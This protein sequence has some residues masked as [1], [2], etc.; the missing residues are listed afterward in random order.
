MVGDHD[1][2]DSAFD[3]ALIKESFAR[4]SPRA[5]HM[6]KYFYAHLFARNPEVREMFPET[7][8]EQRD[9]LVGALVDV[10]LRLDDAPALVAYLEQL[11]RD[12][13]KYDVRA[14]HYPAVGASLLAT[15]EFLAGP[16]W[17]EESAA[18]WAAA[19]RTVAQVMTG[20]ADEVPAATRQWWDADVV[21][22]ERRTATIAVLTVRPRDPFDFVPGQ[23]VSV[24]T[25]AFPKVWRNYSVANAPRQDGT[26]ELHVR[27]VV[28]G[29]VSPALVERTRVGDVLRLGPAVGTMM[30]DRCS[31]RE[32]L[33]VA[34]GTGLAPMKA[35]VEQMVALPQ[36]RPVRM[37]YGARTR[38]DLYDLPTMERLA[39]RYDWLS[40]VPVVS[41]DP[42]YGGH[43]GTLAEAVAG[44]GRWARHD[45][46]VCG[47]PAMV[48]ATVGR[49]TADGVT[50]A[51]V[52]R[53]DLTRSARR[54]AATGSSAPSADPALIRDLLA[55]RR[56]M[57]GPAAR[58][59]YGAAPR[60]GRDD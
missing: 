39:S 5:D 16:A 23:Y 47:S 59:Y 18:A 43:R 10:M 32:V 25:P 56:A 53:D 8:S 35:M 11:G 2:E 37:F 46:Y 54:P 27:R 36:P 58:S 52:R 38:G 4:V 19:Y 55:A 17:T 13:R 26:L 50:S 21:G 41:D 9:R 42:Q 20:A 48:E 30:L 14:E 31:T 28:Q 33:C 60:P 3:P 6:A 45:V 51:Q 7:M 29:L 22:H 15:L 57:R 24:H 12:H 1:A 34:G 49:L 40:V 44:Y